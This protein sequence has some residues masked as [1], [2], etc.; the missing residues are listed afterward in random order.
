MIL[1]K[2]YAFLIKHFKLVHLVLFI[3]TLNILRTY[4]N[5]YTFFND[6]V[7][8][9][10]ATEFLDN[11]SNF[12]GAHTFI[13]LILM[14]LIYFTISLLLINKRKK[15]RIYIISIIAYILILVMTIVYVSVFN[16]MEYELLSANS[17]RVY[18]DIGLIIYLSQYF[19]IIILG[20][21][22]IGFNVKRFNFSNEIEKL[23]LE[24]NDNEEVEIKFN[25]ELTSL[26]KGF[27]KYFREFKYYYKENF[28]IISL[29]I[30]FIIVFIA[31]QLY[32]NS[33]LYTND[34]FDE[35][36]IFSYNGININVLESF[37][38]DKDLGG[39]II[40][41]GKVYL[42]LV[43]NL[44]NTTEENIKIDANQLKIYEDDEYITP[45]ISYSSSFSD[46]GSMLGTYLYSES[47]KTYVIPY[48]IP[49]LEN[50]ENYDLK[51]YTG[52][53]GTGE[54]SQ[55]TNSVVDLK[56]VALNDII[57]VDTY[58]KEEKL[59]FSN[60]PLNNSSL[61][62][63]NYAISSSYIYDKIYINTLGKEITYKE[64][65]QLDSLGK[66]ADKTLLILDGSFTLDDTA[67][68]YYENKNIDDFV[69]NFVE[70]EYNV[71]D[72][73]FIKPAEGIS[74][75]DV[76][77]KIIMKVPSDVKNSDKINLII[78]IRNK[79]YK[80]VIKN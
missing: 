25:V 38:T 75:V 70:I 57:S 19:F 35:G 2:P 41:N 34:T 79:E 8:N 4:Y 73:T 76:E 10:Y 36:E 27:R 29:I 69:N 71:N 3:L 55:A 46:Y 9:N 80:Y 45:K 68:Y 6:F 64:S 30:G 56:P 50:Y 72:K 14:I 7:M 24:H 63:N 61:I 59:V 47:S 51:L 78:T 37:V 20:V 43:V 52:S 39:N 11:T 17:S 62:I 44:E 40:N 13:I 15:S 67:L 1:R 66:D 53:I 12:I 60:T 31:V 23:D 18:Q 21:K 49:S 33:T 77:G 74:N 58:Q 5:I 22:A 28:F 26:K 16:S 42:I 54:S 32:T 65:I 48:E